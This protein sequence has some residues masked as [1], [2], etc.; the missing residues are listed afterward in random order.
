MAGR[1]PPKKSYHHGNL[2]A[3]LVSVATESVRSGGAEDLSLREMA[4][5]VD[6]SPGAVYKHFADRREMLAAVAQEGFAILGRRVAAAQLKYPN[7]YG[8]PAVGIAYVAFAADEPFL[9]DLM[10]GPN[11][12][13]A[14][15][16]SLPASPPGGAFEALRI[17]V[18]ANKG[19]D[20]EQ[21]E[22]SDL[23]LA[24]AAAH[25]AARLVT[26]GLWKRSDP[27][28]EMAI[29]GAI[30]AILKSTSPKP[31]KIGLR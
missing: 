31:K 27:R 25:G 17:A 18:A 22:T 24:W 15:R 29:F 4:R 7:L 2:H 23:A 8:L 5:S 16:A 10:F 1:S 14:R 9:F 21:V 13:N 26:D 28:I 20:P 30:G 12:P 6:V 3:A 19:I 11:G